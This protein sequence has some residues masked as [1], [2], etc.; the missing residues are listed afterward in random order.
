MRAPLALCAGKLTIL[1][2]HHKAWEK[3]D[4][5]VVRVQGA[6]DAF[7]SDTPCSLLSF[8]PLVFPLLLVFQSFSLLPIEVTNESHTY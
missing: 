6:P 7:S 3:L 8:P 1:P 5:M 2:P 4:Q